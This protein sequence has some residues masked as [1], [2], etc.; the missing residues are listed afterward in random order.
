LTIYPAIRFLFH[1]CPSFVKPAGK[2]VS[3]CFATPRFT[4][5]GGVMFTPEVAIW[6]NG[7]NVGHTVHAVFG[8]EHTFLPGRSQLC[9]GFQEVC[10][11]RYGYQRRFSYLSEVAESKKIFAKV[12]C[13]LKCTALYKK[14]SEGALGKLVF[15]RRPYYPFVKASHGRFGN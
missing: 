12:S 10:H 1:P 2:A 8:I 14:G 15:Q 11:R 5:W 13:R 4:Q 6:G 3:R 7:K 9:G